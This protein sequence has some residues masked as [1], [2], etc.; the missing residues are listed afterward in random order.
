MENT[1][2]RRVVSDL[3]LDKLI[4]TE[5]AK[6]NIPRGR[7]DSEQLMANVT[8]L[9]KPYGPLRLSHDRRIAAWCW[10]IGQW[11][12]GRVHLAVRWAKGPA[13]AAQ[14]RAAVAHQWIVHPPI[15]HVGWC[16]NS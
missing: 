6:G 3:T 8:E 10:L 7:K 2:L 13:K 15:S 16:R 5:A 14:P 4:L 1:R 12:A 11:H 9:A